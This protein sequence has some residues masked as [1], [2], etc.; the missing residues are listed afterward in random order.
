MSLILAGDKIVGY[1]EI[2]ADVAK[3]AVGMAVIGFVARSVFSQFLSRDLERYKAN[4][5][6]EHNREMERLKAEIRTNAFEHETRFAR[7]HDKRLEVV[8]EL[9]KL[10]V[11]TNVAFVTWI[12]PLSSASL[13]MEEKRKVAEDAANS[14]FA[15]FDENQI[16]LDE[17]LCALIVRLRDSFRL[18]WANFNI[19]PCPTEWTKVWEQFQSEIPPLR[20]EIEKR[21]RIMLGVN[22][23]QRS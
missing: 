14:F 16:Y 11:H 8:A 5:L 7:L 22:R 21:V 3:F 19:K 2:F 12:A 6:A 20:I 23:N 4:L 17:E 18:A 1:A 10:L 15:F 13:T 9:Y